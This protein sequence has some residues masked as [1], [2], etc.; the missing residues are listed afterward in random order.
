M[1]KTYL[2]CRAAALSPEGH[3]IARSA[4]ILLLWLGGGCVLFAQSNGVKVSNLA[5]SAGTVTFNVS[6]KSADM[7]TLWSDTVWVWV[8]YNNAGKMERLPVTGATASAGTVTK[9][10]N[11]D[12]GV[13][14]AGN[15]RSTGS[16]SATVKLLTAVKDVAGACAYAS[17]YPPV[18]EYSSVAPMISFT[19][20]PE[21]EISLAKSGGGS[22]TV[23]AGDMFLLPCNYTVMSFIDATGMSGQ[24]IGTPFNDNVNA[25]QYAASTKTWRVG[26]QV[27]SDAIRIPACNKEAFTSSTATTQCRSYTSGTSTWYYYNWVYVDENQNTLCPSPWHVP[28]REEVVTLNVQLGG[29]GANISGS[30]A[31][32]LVNNYITL[33]GAEFSGWCRPGGIGQT[34]GESWLWAIDLLTASSAACYT[35]YTTSVSPILSYSIDLGFIV[36]CV[37]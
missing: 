6:W 33:W 37:R 36:R 8:D 30:G 25:P 1:N 16:F 11:N 27:W 10:P 29:T 21:Y 35:V 23:K 3:F 32:A 20:T 19:G 34:G 15:A 5:V 12:K 13:W 22:A 24:L 2:S 26:S 17:N 18:G 14:I 4:F 28:S 9:T 7:P 31:A